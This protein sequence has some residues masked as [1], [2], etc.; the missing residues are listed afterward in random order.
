MA[1][2]KGQSK[3]LT[4]RQKRFAEEYVIDLN[5]EAAAKRAG[6]SA[7][8]ANQQAVH[9]KNIP[10]VAEYIHQLQSKKFQALKID[11]ENVL[12]RILQIAEADIAE[13][14][15][16]RGYLKPIKDIP[17]NVRLCI[18]AVKVYEEFEGQGRDR[19][20]IGEV[21]E[22]KFWNKVDAL[23]ML[24]KHLKLLDDRP[25]AAVQVN[26]ENNT[27]ISLT[28]N[29][30]VLIAKELDKIEDGRWED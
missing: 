6:F 2:K 29:V 26:V 5:G 4:P 14:Y 3:G 1:K 27:N 24:A 22:V 20:Q 28:Q 25:V 18:S 9:L 30:N 17:E 15:D 21:R 19:E 12:R 7:K 8:S 11:A 10:H 13:A 16:D 23:H